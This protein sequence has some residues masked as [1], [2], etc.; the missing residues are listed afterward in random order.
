MTNTRAIEPQI[1]ACF[2]TPIFSFI[3]DN[4]S[5]LEE[6]KDVLLEMKKN[7]EGLQVTPYDWITYDNLHE[8]EKFKELNDFIVSE[9]NSI[10]NYIG[11]ERE[12]QYITSMWSNIATSGHVH[13]CH[14]HPNSFWS[15]ILYLSS[16]EGAPGVTFVDPRPATNVIRPNYS[17]EVDTTFTAAQCHLRSDVGMCYL[18]PS[19]FQH[20]VD[21]G[22]NFEGERISLS[23]NVMIEANIKKFTANWNIK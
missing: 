15:G 11:L 12:D 5:Y 7:E 2:P 8:H 18:F 19:W 22:D 14:S 1:T 23:F 17:L 13:Q 16:P 10:F 6:L 21:G 4:E 3:V 9:F 20:Y